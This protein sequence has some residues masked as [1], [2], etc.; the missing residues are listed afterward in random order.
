MGMRRGTYF[1]I[2]HGVIHYYL[3]NG[4]LKRLDV[5]D[6]IPDNVVEVQDPPTILELSETMKIFLG[7][8]I[9][10]F[11]SI[12]LGMLLFILYHR[13]HLVMQ[14]A[15]GPFLAAISLA[16]VIQIVF[17]V[18]QFP[19]RDA[20]CA[21]KNIVSSV[22]QTFVAATL[23]A[24]VWRAYTTLAAASQFA[25]MHKGRKARII[26]NILLKF[27]DCLAN[28]IKMLPKKDSK[29]PSIRRV[30]SAKDSVTLIS[31]L[32]LPQLIIQIYAAIHFDSSLTVEMDDSQMVGRMVCSNDRNWS[33]SFGFAYLSLIFI[34]AVSIAWISK[35][36]PSV[37]NEKQEIF[38][39]AFIDAFLAACALALMSLLNE[40]TSKPDITVS[41]IISN[42]LTTKKPNIVTKT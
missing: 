11:A 34:L 17:S 18:S 1:F 2:G 38:N 24:R 6:A 9:G 12:A 39:V 31:F 30:V 32:S 29:T 7:C 4:Q 19:T 35:D 28:P 20:F 26:E 40:P 23:V 41:S 37:F 25:R 8:M 42:Y 14:L 16:S 22:P 21:M 27:L 15:Q 3:P 36:L 10:L 33:E 5:A 13:N